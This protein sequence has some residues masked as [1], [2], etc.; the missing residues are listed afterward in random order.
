MYILHLQQNRTIQTITPFLLKILKIPAP[1]RSSFNNKNLRQHYRGT[2]A[3]TC[4]FL[5]LIIWAAVPVL[6]HFTGTAAHIINGR[7]SHVDASSP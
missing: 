4:D 7:K 3:P 5:P 1:S 2:P 6:R